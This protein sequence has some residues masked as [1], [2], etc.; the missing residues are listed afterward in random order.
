MRGLRWRQLNW[1]L[2]DLVPPGT[3]PK[4]GAEA[5][6]GRVLLAGALSREKRLQ[7][8]RRQRPHAMPGPCRHAAQAVE[9]TYGVPGEVVLA[10]WGREIRLRPC[11]HPASG[12]RTCW[13]QGLH[14]RPAR[15]MFTK[16]LVAALQM[17]EQGTA[18]RQ[19]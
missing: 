2:P 16:E 9:K 11:Q 5:E 1:D 7:G 13:R 19:T 6:P 3:K 4:D 10:I 15:S 12:D 8:T 14:G 17:V 18:R